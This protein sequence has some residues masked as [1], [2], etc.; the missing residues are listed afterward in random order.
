MEFCQGEN[1]HVWLEK[2]RKTFDNMNED[3]AKL[4]NRRKA[5]EIFSQTLEGVISMHSKQIVHRDLKPQNIFLDKEDKVKIGDFG[6]AKAQN[7]D[8][9]KAQNEPMST[10]STT[11]SY[12]TSCDQ[13]PD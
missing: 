10:A 3:E 2:Q 4:E 11:E 13:I 12:S 7:E 5:L 1:L 9:Q 8:R 6:L